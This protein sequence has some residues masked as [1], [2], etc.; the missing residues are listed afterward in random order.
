MTDIV[1]RLR[2]A[3]DVLEIVLQR[4][5]AALMREAARIIETMSQELTDAKEIHG[6]LARI[7][8]RLQYPFVGQQR[9]G[10]APS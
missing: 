7:E 8:H 10:P 5:D 9:A 1:E 3:A 2:A 6:A 4:N